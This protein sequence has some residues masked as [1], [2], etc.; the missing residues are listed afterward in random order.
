MLSSVL[1]S[2]IAIR[3]NIRIIRI[4]TQLRQ[5]LQDNTEIRLDIENIRKK[6]DH[7]GKN[8]DLLFGYLD[9]LLEKLPSSTEKGQPIGF[10]KTRH[11]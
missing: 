9:E 1:N 10:M 4:F 8:I 11:S 3:V 5:M 6:L 7:Q 2:E